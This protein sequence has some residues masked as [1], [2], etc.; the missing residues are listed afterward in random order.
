MKAIASNMTMDQKL[1]LDIEDVVAVRLECGTCKTAILISPLDWKETIKQCP[2]CRSLWMDFRNS[3]PP[4]A[5]FIDGL[6]DVIEEARLAKEAAIN[7]IGK[8]AYRV[9]LEVQRPS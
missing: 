2:N 3:K 7:G 5:C 4:A 9:R 1:V 6:R 8:Q